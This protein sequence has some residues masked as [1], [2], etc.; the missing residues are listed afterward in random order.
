MAIVLG[1]QLF[2]QSVA[3]SLVFAKAHEDFVA[4]P[5]HLRRVS[6]SV[7]DSISAL[8]VV[9]LDK[10]SH[11][12]PILELGSQENQLIFVRADADLVRH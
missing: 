8:G 6:P 12:G 11:T 10:I 7:L 9:V 5:D 1:A 2:P 3:H 4:I